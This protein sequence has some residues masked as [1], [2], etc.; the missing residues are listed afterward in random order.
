[1]IS[2]NDPRFHDAF[3][4]ALQNTLVCDT[5][6][7]A[8]HTAY[9]L[10]KRHR[11]VTKNGELIE[12]SGT[13]S[14]GGKPRSGLMSAKVIEEY[15]ENQIL[16]IEGDIRQTT[17]NIQDLKRDLDELKS[18]Q[19]GIQKKLAEAQRARQKANVEVT[20]FEE[21]NKDLETKI[22]KMVNEQKNFEKE[23]GKIQILQTDI[24]KNASV[25][26][27][28]NPQIEDLK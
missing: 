28:I 5:I 13:M 7:I 19:A 3:Y 2:A 10:D 1:M 22:A 27:E 15:S 4:F 16:Q 14:G 23:I 21:F 6:E 9:N 8:T 18:Q 26:T 25:L 12:L 24:Q 20:S 11:V 17:E